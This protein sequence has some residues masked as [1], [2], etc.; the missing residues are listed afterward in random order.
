MPTEETTQQ[1]ETPT[2]T[3]TVITKPTTGEK[4]APWGDNFDPQRAW[5]TIQTL[6]GVESDYNKLKQE[7]EDDHRAKQQQETARLKEQQEFEKLADQ[8]Q[9]RIDELE[10]AANK[11]E[12]YEAA[13]KV[14]LDKEREGLPEHIIELLDTKD[15]ADQLEYIAKNREALKPPTSTRNGIERTPE[16]N[17]RVDRA[18]LIEQEIAA[19]RSGRGRP[20]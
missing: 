11:A 12:R 16:G 2:T 10:P 15:V 13:L 20:Y 1:G 17:G 3:E 4:P 7:R 19:Q 9:E 5:N 14:H 8:R 6:R 18:A